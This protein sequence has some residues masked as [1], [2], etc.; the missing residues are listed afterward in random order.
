MDELNHDFQAL[1]LEGRAMGEVSVHTII[2]VSLHVFCSLSQEFLLSL[3]CCP[4]SS[5]SQAR[6]SGNLMIQGRMDQKGS[7]WTSG[8]T[9]PGDPLVICVPRCLNLLVHECVFILKDQVFI[10]FF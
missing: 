10:H 2:F 4:Y 7:F 9:V 8:E 5:F 6:S 1:A 3:I